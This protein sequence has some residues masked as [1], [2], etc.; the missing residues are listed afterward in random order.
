ML[1]YDNIHGY[2]EISDLATKI[3]DTSEFQRMR[4]INQTGGLSWVYPTASHTRFEHSI[5]TYFLANELINNIKN[6]QPELGVSDRLVELLSI[7]GLCHDLGHVC[8]SHLFDDIFLDDS[9]KKKL[10]KLMIHESRSIFIFRHI[11]KKY[12]ISITDDE[13]QIICDMIYPEIN[14]YDEWPKEF[15][16]GKFILSIISNE[17]NSLDVD[18][19]D[20][21]KRDSNKT[22]LSLSIDYSRLL[23]QARVID[24]KICYPKQILKEIYNLFFVRYQLY[25]Q[26]YTHKAVRG[27]DLVIR[28][29]LLELEKEYKISDWILDPEKYKYLTDDIIYQFN[30]PDQVKYHTKQLDERKFYK[31]IYEM[32]IDV[33]DPKKYNYKT[34]E[35]EVVDIKIG[36]VS[37]N[38]ENPLLNVFAYDPKDKSK[39]YLADFEKVIML[40][41]TKYQERFIRIYSKDPNFDYRKCSENCLPFGQYND[42]NI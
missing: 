33:E 28:D 23:L 14:F 35:Y 42:I 36:F 22:G 9:K 19:F 32:N 16:V 29:C 3:I 21:L 1:I 4:R 37:G 6:N 18:K 17:L 39:C 25:K 24:D 13:I 30:V 5:G 7:A 38:K 15:K 40:K 8:F 2:I 34:D 31:L 27:V 12:K 26:L 10:G 11:I 20:Y 41:P